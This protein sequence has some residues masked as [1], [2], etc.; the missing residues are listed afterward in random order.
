MVE[1]GKV[2]DNSTQG[3]TDLSEKIDDL[4]MIIAQID[5]KASK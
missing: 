3:T 4:Q 1:L 5:T 2:F